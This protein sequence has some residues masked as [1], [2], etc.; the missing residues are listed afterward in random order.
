MK[1]NLNIKQNNVFLY[2]KHS[3]LSK[4]QNRWRNIIIQRNM[5]IHVYPCVFQSTQI[6]PFLEIYI[7]GF[8]VLPI[9]ELLKVT[10]LMEKQSYNKKPASSEINCRQLIPSLGGCWNINK[11]KYDHKVYYYACNYYMEHTT[12]YQHCFYASGYASGEVFLNQ[13]CRCH[14]ELE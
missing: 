12:R 11:N 10:S 6:R 13:L 1:G 7:E 4:E 3:D 5:I 9:R 14:I 2:G 8:I